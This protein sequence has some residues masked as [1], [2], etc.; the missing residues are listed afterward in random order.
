MTV[1]QVTVQHI[2]DYVNHYSDDEIHD[3]NTIPHD[4]VQEAL[5]EV[6]V[7]HNP[8]YDVRTLAEEWVD[9]NQSKEDFAAEK[10]DAVIHPDLE[11]YITVEHR[12]NWINGTKEALITFAP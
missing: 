4:E 10:F 11:R 12:N 5:Y 6:M 1:T 3:I 8:D 2:I 7:K 9:T